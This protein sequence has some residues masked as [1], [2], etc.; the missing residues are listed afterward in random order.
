MTVQNPATKNRISTG[1]KV[2]ALLT[3]VIYLQNED[4]VGN[5]LS[6]LKTS[7]GPLVLSFLNAHAVNL[8]VNDDSFFKNLMSSQVLLRDGVG[9]KIAA[10]SLGF[11]PG[12]N[13]N[14]TDFIPQILQTFSGESIALFGTKDPNLSI[15]KEVIAKKYSGNVLESLHGFLSPEEYLSSAQR[16]RPRV[17][18]LAMGMPKQESVAE[19]LKQGLKHQCLIINGGAI[20]D[21]ISNQVPRA[22]VLFRQWGFEWLWRLMIEPKRLWKRYLIGNGQFLLRILKIKFFQIFST[23]PS[24]GV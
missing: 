4:A 2:W 13:M 23:D 1:Q 9:I 5:M 21:Y 12:K 7:Q 16:L 8:A 22:P 6:Q 18:I 10:S 24:L 11:I 14:G 3:K 15:A 19:L 17:I 20:L